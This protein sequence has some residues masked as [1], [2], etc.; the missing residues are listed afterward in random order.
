MLKWTHPLPLAKWK[1]VLAATIGVGVLIPLLTVHGQSQPAPA[2]PMT[3]TD[4]DYIEIKQLVARYGFAVDTGNNNGYDY[5]DLFSADGE[6]IRPYSKGRE[7]L[8]ALAR[9]GR[10]GPNNVVHYITNHVIEPTAEGAIGREY[11]F[12]L[13]FGQAGRGQNA[14]GQRGPAASPAAPGPDVAA[15]PP[16]PAQGGRG[17]GGAVNQWDMIGRKN[18]ELAR[19]GGH[20]EDV[21]VKTSDGWRFKRRDF[22]P[23]KRG[24][25]PAPLAPPRIPPDADKG[26][27]AGPLPPSHFVAP[28]RQSTLTAMDYIQIE[29]L[30]ASYGHALDS[31]YGKGENGEAYA[32]LYTPDAEFAGAAGHDQLVALAR[33]Q[34]RGP[35]YVRHYLTNHVIEPAPEGARGKQYLVVFDI[36]EKGEPGSIY[37]GGHY[38][39]TYTKTQDGWRFK[40]RRLFPARPAIPAPAPTPAAR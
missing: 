3:L 21:Y 15:N 35:A 20:Y 13:T 33:A 7:Q 26:V 2:K 36:S 8:A 14:G 40:T 31:G 10:L 11:L 30:V 37:L 28:T 1:A 22:I 27:E 6:F 5:A 9:G 16:P 23:S 32:S 39:D 24:P 12:E 19:T 29:Q 4:L 38:E 18:G 25:N 17:P 34:P